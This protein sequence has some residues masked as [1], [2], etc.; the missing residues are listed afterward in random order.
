MEGGKGVKGGLKGMVSF[1]GGCC[2]CCCGGCAAAANGGPV[3]GLKGQPCKGP[4]VKSDAEVCC[5]LKELA[6]G[7]PPP[8]AVGLRPSCCV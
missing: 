4:L 1:K 5:C 7:V 6:F 3:G 8:K 2:G